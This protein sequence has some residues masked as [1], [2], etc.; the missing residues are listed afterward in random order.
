M[1]RLGHQ[2]GSDKYLPYGHPVMSKATVVGNTE[3]G[4]R[5]ARAGLF[6]AHVGIADGSAHCAAVRAPVLKA[7]ASARALQRCVASAAFYDFHT[8]FSVFSLQF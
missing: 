5:Q 3:L 8:L 1:S 2:G 7:T 6:I 4:C